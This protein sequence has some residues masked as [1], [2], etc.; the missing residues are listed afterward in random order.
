MS[1][2]SLGRRLADEPDFPLGYLTVSPSAG[3]VITL[4]QE[5]RVEAL[6]MAVLVT[7]VRAGGATV[8]RDALIEQCWQGRIVSDD[9]VA[10]AIA[11]VRALERCTS[12][13]PFS[14]ETVPKVGY[15]LTSAYGELTPRPAGPDATEAPR[16]RWPRPRA[17]WLAVGGVLAAGALIGAMALRPSPTASPAP[18]GRLA[19]IGQIDDSGL[20]RPVRAGDVQDA[21]LA[22][23]EPR[24]RDYLQRGWNPDWSLDSEKNTA[25]HNLMMACERNPAHDREGMLKA[26]R[27]LV[28]AGADP[29]APNKWNDTPLAIGASPRYCGP[30]HPV[31]AYLRSVAATRKAR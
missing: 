27:L 23:D 13:A 20:R 9:A 3:R 19:G 1:G 7:L 26:A 14:L 24:L 18:S 30:D 12:P 10:R 21:V 17:A 25:L 16:R 31:V 2:R 4:D 6:T 28:E 11:K 29:T 22:V 15:R 5:I 8:T